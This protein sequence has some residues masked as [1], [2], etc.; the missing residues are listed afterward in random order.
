MKASLT[1]QRRV[2]AII[3]MALAVVVTL[4]A[5]GNSY[6][7][8]VNNEKLTLLFDETALLERA[9]ADLEDDDFDFVIEEEGLKTVQIYGADDQLLETV[10][11]GEG[12]VIENVTTQQMLN[13]AEFLSAYGNTMVYK[14]SE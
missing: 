2:S 1:N 11:L 13:K 8:T 12:E 10:T 5:G 14:I 3:A 4:M 7:E 6:G 9:I